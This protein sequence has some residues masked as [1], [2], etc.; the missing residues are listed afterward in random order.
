MSNFEILLDHH[1]DI[2]Q[3]HVF[4]LIFQKESITKFSKDV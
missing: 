4:D 3:K 1:G 2:I